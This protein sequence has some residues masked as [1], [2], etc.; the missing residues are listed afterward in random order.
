MG[1]TGENGQGGER[2]RESRNDGP[3]LVEDAD[4]TS[5]RKCTS[6]IRGPALY[7]VNDT[8]NSF[9]LHSRIFTHH[10]QKVLLF[11]R[12]AFIQNLAVAILRNL[13]ACS[14]TRA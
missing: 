14:R 4:G 9:T 13:L 5:G 10:V 11:Y 12:S 1:D 6:S 7:V 3:L 8:H 2:G